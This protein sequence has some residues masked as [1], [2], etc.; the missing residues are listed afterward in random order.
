MT[1][2]EARKL[3]TCSEILDANRWR[4]AWQGQHFEARALPDTTQMTVGDDV[5]CHVLPGSTELVAVYPPLA[6]EILYFTPGNASYAAHGTLYKLTSLT[7]APVAIWT[8]PNA[9]E[10]ISA[11]AWTKL[12]NRLYLFT[13][14]D[15]TGRPQRIYEYDV[16]T[17]TATLV[18]GPDTSMGAVAPVDVAEFGGNLYV[19]YGKLA[20]SYLMRFNPVTYAMSTVNTITPAV[21]GYQGGVAVQ[22]G[23]LVHCGGDD[24]WLSASGNPASF[25]Q[26]ADI[27]P[28]WDYH[29]RANSLTTHTADGKIYLNGGC[30]QDVGGI[31]HFVVYSWDGASL[32]AEYDTSPAR[33][34]NGWGSIG[35]AYSGAVP[36]DVYGAEE[37]KLTVPK[38]ATL[39]KRDA[40]A[41]GADTSVALPYWTKAF[42]NLVQFGGKTLWLVHHW[43]STARLLQRDSAGSLT[44]LGNWNITVPYGPG[45]PC[46]TLARTDKLCH[47]I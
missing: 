28:L 30:C 23:N 44:E 47:E 46:M 36:G 15:I 18:W 16:A 27:T 35:L 38:G 5:F 37:G 34:Y 17:D 33:M 39:Y 41:W 8:A 20:Y 45:N 40:G 9:D 14:R 21:N 6:R 25:S 26:V 2:D 42:Q 22:G 29:Q 1:I 12:T 43:P 10:Y 4:G 19:V 11:L 3:V 32:V 7:V 24:L 31:Y 13:C